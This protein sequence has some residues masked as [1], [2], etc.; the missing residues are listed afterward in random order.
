MSTA[1]GI[2]GCRKGW[3]YFRKDTSGIS[4]GLA[5]SLSRLVES[6]PHGSRVSIDIP[7]G[8]SDGTRACDSAARRLLAPLRSASVFPAPARASLAAASYDEAKVL[9]QAASGKKLSRQTFAILPK[10]REVDELLSVNRDA[11]SMLR[12][13][14]PELCFWAM[15]GGQPMVHSK[16]TEAG[17]AERLHLLKDHLPTAHSLIEHVLSAYR[18][19]DVA[20]DDIVDA[21]AC[22]V[23]AAAPAQRLRPVPADPLSDGHGIRMQ[24]LTLTP[25]T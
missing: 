4:H 7:I 15:N 3:F 13:T 14:H 2:D 11:R 19:K 12:E 23:V 24:I 25:F 20:R 10:I 6:L 8:L 9:N 21:L 5:E 22:L 18:R 16:K 1:L 17:F